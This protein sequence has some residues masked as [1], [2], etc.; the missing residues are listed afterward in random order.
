M[1]D[2]EVAYHHIGEVDGKPVVVAK[3][4]H[5]AQA[6]SDGCLPLDVEEVKLI[7]DQKLKLDSRSSIILIKS[8]F[9]KAKLESVKC[10]KK[11]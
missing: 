10:R 6:I 4:A 5:F 7:T 3:R 8:L 2:Q 11:L 1:D 9:P